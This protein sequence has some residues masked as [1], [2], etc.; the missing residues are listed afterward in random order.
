MSNVSMEYTNINLE[1]ISIKNKLK[2]KKNKFV[3]TFIMFVVAVE[4]QFFLQSCQ[5]SFL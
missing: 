3:I 5:D 4:F 1:G 2:N